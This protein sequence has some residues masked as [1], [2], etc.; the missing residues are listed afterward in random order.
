MATIY[1]DNRANASGS[2]SALQSSS[3]GRLDARAP[4]MACS[5]VGAENP[6]LSWAKDGLF[7]CDTYVV[8]RASCPDSIFRDISLVNIDLSEYLSVQIVKRMP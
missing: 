4:A 2:F 8:T 5:D 3:S 1:L 6:L 7:F